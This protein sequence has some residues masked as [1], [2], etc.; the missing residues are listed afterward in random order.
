MPSRL[1]VLLLGR[2][3]SVKRGIFNQTAAV[4]RRADNVKTKL[5]FDKGRKGL[6]NR[7]PAAKKNSKKIDKVGKSLRDADV[8]LLVGPSSESWLQHLQR[9]LD[10]NK[11]AASCARCAFEVWA[12][13]NLVPKWMSWKPSTQGGIGGLGCCVCAASRTSSDIQARRRFL[14]AEYKQKGISK[15]SICRRA[16]WSVYGVRRLFHSRQFASAI[17]MHERTDAHKMAQNVFNSPQFHLSL[18]QS[19]P[20]C[21]RFPSC[22]GF[23]KAERE[24]LV[25]EAA[26]S[27]LPKAKGIVS[28]G[29]SSA[30]ETTLI[31]ERVL[32][33][34]SHGFLHQAGSVLD[35][36]RGNVPQVQDWVECWAESTERISMRKQSRLQQKKLQIRRTIRTKH[37][38]RKLVLVMASVKRMEIRRKLEEAQSISLGLDESN[39]R[40][41]IRVRGDALK[42]PFTFEAVLGI[43]AKSYD[44][45]DIA[46]SLRED[47]AQHTSKELV[48]FFQR[49]FTP[50]ATRK[51]GRGARGQPAASFCAEELDRFRRKVRV[52]TS[53]GGGSERR[54]L[55]LQAESF[56]VNAK[57]TIRDPAHA[58]RIALQVPLRME[59]MYKEV[60]DELMNK[61]HALIPD[62]KNSGK[63][64][65][66]LIAIQ[67]QARAEALGRNHHPQSI[68]RQGALRTVLQH[69]SFARQRM[70]S[71]ADPLAKF[72]LMLMPITLLLSFV[73]TDERCPKSQRERAADLLMKMQAKFVHAAAVASD[74]GLIAIA[75]LRLYYE[76]YYNYVPTLNPERIGKNAEHSFFSTDYEIR[77]IVFLLQKV[78]AAK[79][80]RTW[81]CAHVIL[82]HEARPHP[83]DGTWLPKQ[84]RPYGKHLF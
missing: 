29:A 78:P 83:Y 79:I 6:S 55:F 2:S 62:I 80:I 12:R 73:S 53:D 15:Q 30:C 64:K 8:S 42:K 51:R 31:G 46:K 25:S 71:T 81:L 74:W 13:G 58:I 36:F 63:W 69:L 77:P 33:S 84:A 48:E 59:S 32:P 68:Y 34:S 26:S 4:K 1:A 61:R 56:F 54:A 65:K 49:F 23:T 11:W 75:F 19:S 21:L 14:S 39:T 24:E 66:M 18:Q 67:Q 9:H 3:S 5:W 20:N 44:K 52:L 27:A 70:D 57:Y 40:K 72:C 38:N 43:V 22:P 10:P 28:E 60:F 16:A 82:F 35:P 45:G 17:S 37:Q 41:V 47:H 7:I 76:I 50:L